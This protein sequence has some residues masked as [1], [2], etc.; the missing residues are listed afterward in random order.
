MEMRADLMG[1]LA[2]RFDL[3]LIKGQCEERRR[4]EAMP[5]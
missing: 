3:L 4:L 1:V 2:D 5:G